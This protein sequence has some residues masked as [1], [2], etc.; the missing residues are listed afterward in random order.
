[1][2]NPENYVTDFKMFTNDLNL[3]PQKYLEHL[4][5]SIFKINAIISVM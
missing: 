5:D 2:L 3:K 1:M 4:Y